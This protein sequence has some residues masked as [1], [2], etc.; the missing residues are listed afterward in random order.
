MHQNVY[1]PRCTTAL[2]H[3]ASYCS[4]CRLDVRPI[5]A[6]LDADA[7]TFAYVEQTRAS[8]YRRWRRQRH[9]LGLLLVFG[10]LL[11][12]CCIPISIGLFGISAG[13]TIVT[14]LAGVA[15]VLLLLGSMLLLAA[16]G[17]I[18]TVIEPGDDTPTAPPP[19]GWTL[20]LRDD[21]PSVGTTEHDHA[22]LPLR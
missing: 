4:T 9:E 7:S 19:A 16:E 6:I 11:V 2:E 3:A 20:P 12:G 5:I 10:S 1:C 14:L 18:L 21:A 22:T 17:R 15:G 13:G 8:R